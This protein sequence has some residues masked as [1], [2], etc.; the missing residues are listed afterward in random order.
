MLEEADAMAEEEATAEKEAT[1]VQA[2]AVKATS[3]EEA[4]RVREVVA[5]EGGAGEVTPAA[6][7]LVTC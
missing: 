2:V 7:N 1:A 4:V 6:P 5:A 3:R